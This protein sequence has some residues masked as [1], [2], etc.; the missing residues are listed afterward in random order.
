MATIYDLKPRFQALLRPLC[1]RLAAS[2]ITANQVTLL[3]CA[4]SLLHGFLFYMSNGARLWLLLLPVTLFLRMAL[5]AIDGMLAREHNQKTRLGAILNEVTDV[6]SDAALYL[7]F[8]AV[9]GLPPAVV[10]VAVILA[11]VT[12]LTGLVG[13]T[14]NAGRRYDGPMGKSDRAFAFGLLAVLLGLGLAPG[15]WSSLFV[16]VIVLLLAATIYNRARKSVR[17]GLTS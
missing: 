15:L 12:E 1:Q 17:P 8:A 3:A 5:N 9:P 4:M 13:Q 2:G 14:L 11:A 10:A 6:V 7:P 16:W